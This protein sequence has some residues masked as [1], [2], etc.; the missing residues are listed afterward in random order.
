M[1]PRVKEVQ[2]TNDYVLDLVFTNQE[3]KQFDVKPYL[4]FGMFTELKDYSIFRT[5]KVEFG[6]VSW[7]NGLDICPDTLY[8]ESK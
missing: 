7:S 1:N 2:V 5:A 3:K 6:T 4:N 8:I